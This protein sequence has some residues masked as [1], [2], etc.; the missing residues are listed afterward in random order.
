[1]INSFFCKTHQVNILE[2]PNKKS[3]IS[4]Q[5]IYGEKFRILATYKKFYK[6]QSLDDNYIGYIK[7]IK[8]INKFKANYKV[9]VLKSKIYIG[10][11]G[12]R[13]KGTKEFLPFA[14]N[15]EILKKRKKF[16][17]FE[18]NKWLKINDICLIKKSEK[19]FSKILKLFLNCPY[20]WG[21]KTYRGIDCSAL[22]QIYYKF[23]NKFFPRDTIDQ[24]KFNKGYK[25]KKI[26][27]KGD[28]IFWKGHVA[29]CLNSKQLLHAYGPRK[30]VVLMPIKKTIKLIE[31][32]TKLKV[33][34][35]IKL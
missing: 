8:K 22:I 30:K 16:V 29:M 32:T 1:M 6:I 35:I 28:I 10:S 3:N 33:K 9:K 34:K 19:N 7:K 27:S 11:E 13:K 18:K 23:N 5:L 4:S 21:G 25:N 24:I 14:S 31:K 12:Q 15:L 26:F 17:M 2:K 20:K